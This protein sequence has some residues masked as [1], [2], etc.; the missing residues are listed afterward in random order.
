MLSSKGHYPTSA[1]SLEILPLTITVHCSVE[2]GIK[3][4]RENECNLSIM[5]S[6]AQV[7]YKMISW[8]VI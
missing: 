3:D 7:L 6:Y 8:G 2:G 1:K 5:C 4:E